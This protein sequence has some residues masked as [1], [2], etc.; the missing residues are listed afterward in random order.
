MQELLVCNDHLIGGGR[1]HKLGV[2]IFLNVATV[3]QF[4]QHKKYIKYE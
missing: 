1:F 3:I 4:T 2:Y